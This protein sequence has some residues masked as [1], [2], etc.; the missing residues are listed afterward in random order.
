MVNYYFFNTNSVLGGKRVRV[1]KIKIST[2]F[3][4]V[5]VLFVDCVVKTK[6]CGLFIQ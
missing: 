1:P 4:L 2:I 3:T 6:L 5:G